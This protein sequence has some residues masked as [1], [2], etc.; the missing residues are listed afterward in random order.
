MIYAPEKQIVFKNSN[1]GDKGGTGVEFMAQIA[2]S[3]DKVILALDVKNSTP[4]IL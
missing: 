1:Q 2:Q 3:K 4:N